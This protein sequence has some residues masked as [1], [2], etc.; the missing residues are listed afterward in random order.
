MYMFVIVVF[1]LVVVVGLWLGGMWFAND[2]SIRR[3]D[4]RRFNQ[5]LV[6]FPH[7][8]DETNV[9]GTL[10]R[11]RQ[12]G[13][14]ITLLV[15]TK[16]EHGT[17]DA[18][19]DLSLKATRSAEM[20]HAGKLLG[21]N[22]L[23]QK[24]LGDGE[25]ARHRIEA[26][27]CIDDAI[28]DTEPDLIITYDLAGLYGHE[29][30]IACA[31]EVV[32]CLEN[33]NSRVTLWYSA[34]PP[35]LLSLTNLPTHMAKDPNFAKKRAKPNIRIAIGPRGVVAKINSIYAHASQR[36]SFRESVPLRAPLWLMYS[37][38]INEYFEEVR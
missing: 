3:F 34:V 29:D 21:V 33:Y 5:V 6:I 2:F 8:D 27:K 4:L 15:L 1:A 26:Q 12:Q 22:E 13:A 18:H 17:P 19:L 25:V 9:A 28:H 11:L 20:R 31:E 36:R 30:H 10:L 38:R 7:P 35:R 37:M 16:G 24:D 32:R 14:H 23:I